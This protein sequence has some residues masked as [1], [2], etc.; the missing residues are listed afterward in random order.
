MKHKYGIMIGKFR[1]VNTELMLNMFKILI[2]VV[3][4][5][6]YNNL[7]IDSLFFIFVITLMKEILKK[8]IKRGFISDLFQLCCFVLL[9]TVICFQILQINQQNDDFYTDAV[10][11]VVFSFVCILNLLFIFRVFLALFREFQEYITIKKNTQENS[12]M[13]KLFSCCLK[14]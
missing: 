12:K 7:V 10:K 1:N 6:L 8:V 5:L 11:I 2:V 3:L 14:K 4:F 13:V 9:F